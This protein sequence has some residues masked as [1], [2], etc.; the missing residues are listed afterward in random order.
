[1]VLG[2]ECTGIFGWDSLGEAY[3]FM[4]FGDDEI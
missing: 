1:M 4:D 3:G 2:D